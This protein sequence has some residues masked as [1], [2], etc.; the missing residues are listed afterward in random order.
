MKNGIEFASLVVFIGLL[1]VGVIHM[2]LLA[3]GFGIPSDPD[4]LEI[5]IDKPSSVATV[6]GSGYDY[7][8]D[9][10]GNNVVVVRDC[11]ESGWFGYNYSAKQ[12]SFYANLQ[13][14][15]YKND[16]YYV[17]SDLENE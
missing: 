11:Y 15:K 16:R 1:I 13:S 6:Y 7:I 8:K 2:V 3:V 12:K 4:I 17:P 5:Q 9:D 14:A 10:Q